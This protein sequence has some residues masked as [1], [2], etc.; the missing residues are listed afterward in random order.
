[1]YRLVRLYGGVLKL[2]HSRLLVLSNEKVTNIQDKELEIIE[3]DMINISNLSYSCQKTAK[4]S[5][6]EANYQS[7][8]D[9]E[10]KSVKIGDGEPIQKLSYLYADQVTAEAT[11]QKVY[12]DSSLDNDTLSITKVGDPD[13]ISGVPIKIN[14]LRDD[15]YPKSCI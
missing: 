4:Y 2:T 10:I 12:N 9:A 7:T 13:I 15:I 11:A 6:V 5:S 1:M 8:D 14:G 3:I